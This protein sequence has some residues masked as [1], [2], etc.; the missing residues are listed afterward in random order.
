MNDPADGKG[1]DFMFSQIELVLIAEALDARLTTGMFDSD[2]N[3][4]R[5]GEI[6][7]GSKSHE[8]ALNELADKVVNLMEA[9]QGDD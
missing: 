2:L 6:V 1:K 4:D 5:E 9:E 8:I 7:F 3:P